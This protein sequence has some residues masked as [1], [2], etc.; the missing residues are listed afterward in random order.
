MREKIE[1]L[2]TMETVVSQVATNKFVVV[3]AAFK[4]THKHTLTHVLTEQ[5]N[6]PKGSNRKRGRITQLAADLR[7]Y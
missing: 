4:N 7:K 6:K 5:P 1:Q 3:L 2:H